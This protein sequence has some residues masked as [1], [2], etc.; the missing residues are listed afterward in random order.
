MR[1]IM[2]PLIS[3][4]A[5]IS[6]ANKAHV[7]AAETVAP[8]CQILG[9][10]SALDG[11]V[12][13]PSWAPYDA[14][15][16]S[17][18]SLSAALRPWCMVLPSS[19]EDVSV[20][21]K[22]LVEHHCHFGIRAGGHGGFPLSNS[23][24]DGVTIDLGHMNTTTWNP[25][26]GLAS[27]Q[28]GSQ[29]QH[30]YESL[31]PH[32]VVV[33]GARIDSVGVGG[34]LTGGGLSFHKESHG[35]ACDN[36]ANFEVVLASGE[37][38]NANASSHRDLWQALKGSSGNL[39]IVTRFDMYGIEY[40]DPA[41]PV[42]WGGAV[43]Y[44]ESL[45]NRLIDA[46]VDFTDNIHKDENSSVILAWAY[47][48][49]EEDATLI[50][51]MFANTEAKVKPA[52]FDGF[53]AAEGML[54]DDTRVASMAH[55]VKELGITQVAGNH[56]A[57]YVSAFQSDAR[58]MQFAVKRFYELQKELEEVAPSPTS[59]LNVALY[60]QSL[61][62][63]MT[64]KGIQKG[65]NVIGLER[66]TAKSNGILM[67]ILVTV[68]D[69]E[70]EKLIVPRVEKFTDD[71]DLYAASLKLKWEWRYLN[72]ACAVQDAIASYGTR[73]VSM[74]RAAAEKYDASAVF[75]SLR[76]SGFK[77][78]KDHYSKTEL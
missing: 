55:L 76:V 11:K 28:P 5:A 38:V 32:G 15:L 66:F 18:W 4:V 69:A 35:Q 64:D 70:S 72:Y 1:I 57:W 71:V 41:K 65:G 33:A 23:V 51:A 12:Y 62:K 29:W 20:I 3:I 37:I 34:F 59:G 9:D 27:I 54:S 52:A 73:S 74:I 24:Q 2:K 40:A 7:L 10:A 21:M 16:D 26:T 30:V 22:L 61:S 63:S 46:M 44:P 56:N 31:A 53:Y 50:Q 45:G 49:A 75:Q 43:V 78:P 36:V 17:Y 60:F 47:N 42:V 25:E 39:G 68:K 58:P 77:I 67:L 13:L 14:R 8:C 6:V 19:A 48:P